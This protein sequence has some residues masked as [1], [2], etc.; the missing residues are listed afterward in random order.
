M[1]FRFSKK[2]IVALGLTG[3]TTL[4]MASMLF[5]ANASTT[6]PSTEDFVSDL[7]N[8]FQAQTPNASTKPSTDTGSSL[9]MGNP[10]VSGSNN[11]NAKGGMG[12]LP[13]PLSKPSGNSGVAKTSATSGGIAAE[14]PTAVTTIRNAPSDGLSATSNGTSASSVPNKDAVSANASDI[15]THLNSA[16]QCNLPA[17]DILQ[18]EELDTKTVVRWREV[19]GAA[20]YDVMKRS[21]SGEFVMIERV[22][23]P[24][25][26]A[27]LARGSVKYEDFKVAAVCGD[28][29]S[30]SI[31]T[32]KVTSVKTGPVQ[33][34]AIL[35]ISLL[36]SAAIILRKKFAKN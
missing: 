3:A 34:L 24:I 8:A 23:T 1:Y 9:G 20:A 26:T 13:I 29:E 30:P 33:T 12:I 6:T 11:A 32:S 2:E 21:K 28:T 22:K 35:V 18:T 19:P 36:A 4:S 7:E 14:K 25:Y 27:H 17:I 10:T 5:F 31:N 15:T 16:K